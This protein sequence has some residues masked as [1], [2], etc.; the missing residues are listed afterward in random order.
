MT[1]S[2]I[3]ETTS[4]KRPLRLRIIGLTALGFCVIG[5]AGFAAAFFALK[6]GYITTATCFAIAGVFGVMG[7]A[8]LW[9]GAACLGLGI[10]TRRRERFARWG[11]RLKSLFG[12]AS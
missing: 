10:Y 12:R 3:T 9:V 5:Y 7:E 11:E 6:A 8:G 4:T 2:T 1:V